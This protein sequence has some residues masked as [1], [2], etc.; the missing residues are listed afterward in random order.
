YRVA[1]RFAQWGEERSARTDPRDRVGQGQSRLAYGNAGAFG[2]P[3]GGGCVDS[4]VSER[5]ADPGDKGD[6]SAGLYRVLP[7]GSAASGDQQCRRERAVHHRGRCGKQSR[8]DRDRAVNR[9]VHTIIEP[10]RIKSVEPLHHT[11]REARERFL[12]DASYNLFLI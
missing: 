4:G 5:H 7:G 12:E 2:E 10:F 11:T 8:T 6:A 1:A 3:A 9:A